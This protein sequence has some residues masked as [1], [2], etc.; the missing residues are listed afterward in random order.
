VAVTA[1][2]VGLNRGPVLGWT[3]PL[4]LVSFLVFPIA[5]AA[6]VLAE[7]RASAPLLPLAFLRRRNFA[8][9]IANQFFSNFAY[10]GGFILAPVLLERVFHFS[11]AH[12]GV[13]V[14]ARP[15]AF[16]LTAP[17]AGYLA[18]RIGD[19]VSVV[20]GSLVLGGS[21][22][23]FAAVGLQSSTLMV[24]AA[25]AL[26]GVG[27]GIA[28]PSA[29][30]AVA[31]SVDED[32]LG[33]ASAAQQLMAQVGVVA[34]IQVLQTI[35]SSRQAG[36]LVASFHDAYLVGALACLLAAACAA[37]ML[38]RFRAAEAFNASEMPAPAG[39]QTG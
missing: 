32:S 16:S 3:S 21:M 37:G 23:V 28:S 31:N 36:G 11:D 38:G 25:L 39:A 15:L 5:S 26:S 34:G 14:I 8:M 24:V 33:V 20:A 6:F 35:Q 4:V 10:M 17:V 9:P 19:R 12:A 1:F 29:A 27:L 2:L 30:A 22:L 7:R 18:G 13:T